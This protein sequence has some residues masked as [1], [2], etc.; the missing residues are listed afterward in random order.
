MPD[1]LIWFAATFAWRQALAPAQDA[2]PADMPSGGSTF[3][4][5]DP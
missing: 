5:I 4:C 3:S 1:A 2:S